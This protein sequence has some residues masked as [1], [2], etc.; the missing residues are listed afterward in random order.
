MPGCLAAAWSLGQRAA[1][2]T[3]RRF[4]Q[5]IRRDLQD[6]R[7]LGFEDSVALLEGVGDVFEE[8]EAEDDVFVVRGV[9]VAAEL[10]GGLPESLLEA[11]VGAVF[12]CF[13]FAFF[14]A[15]HTGFRLRAYQGCWAMIFYDW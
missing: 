1:L 2:E 15:R 5:R 3:R 6:W 10:V 8:D 9:H 14:A 11:E 12:R 7:G 13:L 4:R